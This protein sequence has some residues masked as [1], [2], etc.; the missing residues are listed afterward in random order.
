GA[1]AGYHPGVVS[2]RLSAIPATVAVAVALAGCSA[3]PH[4]NAVTAAARSFVAEVKAGDGAAACALL[5][6]D[7]RSSAPGATDQ[8]CAQAV[9][10]VKEQGEAV[11]GVQVWGDAAQ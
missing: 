11:G 4:A 5:T 6:D 3:T 1:A 7:A 2:A 10:N 9:A 8:S